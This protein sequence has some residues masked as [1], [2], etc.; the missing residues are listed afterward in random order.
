MSDI[1]GDAIVE[2]AQA[3]QS[4]ADFATFLQLLLRDC[5][6]NPDEWENDT[7]ERFLEAM[8]SFVSDMEGYYAGINIAVDL[9][10]PRWRQFADILL[11]A[12]VYE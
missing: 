1:S 6:E 12:R 8:S 2:R 3:I 4:K 5:R 9:D 11:A 7:L 10:K